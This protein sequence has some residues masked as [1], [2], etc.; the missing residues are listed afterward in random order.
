MNV[1][2][3]VVVGVPGLVCVD[4]KVPCPLL[5]LAVK[6]EPDP[7]PALLAPELADE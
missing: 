3:C 4:W 7:S 6:V 2:L 1:P 5:L